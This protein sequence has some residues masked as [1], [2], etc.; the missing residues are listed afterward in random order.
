MTVLPRLEMESASGKK[1]A[2]DSNP[3]NQDTEEGI[4][5][6]KVFLWRFSFRCFFVFR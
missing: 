5:Y 3:L 4:G 1:K 6:E 2:G